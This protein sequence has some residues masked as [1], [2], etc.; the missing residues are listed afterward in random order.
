MK[1]CKLC[2]NTKNKSETLCIP[3][4]IAQ[5]KLESGYKIWKDRENSMEWK[6]YL[7]TLL[8]IPTTGKLVKQV[9]IEEIKVYEKNGSKTKN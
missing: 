1:L 3:H 5:D 6:K 9:I 4:K 7:K 8:E 2:N